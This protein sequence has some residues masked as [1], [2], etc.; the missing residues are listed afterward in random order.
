MQARE[1]SEWATRVRESGGCGS[2]PTRAGPGFWAVR[3]GKK[4][5]CKCGRAGESGPGDARETG[6]VR[7]GEGARG[8]AGPGSCRLGRRRWLGKEVSWVRVVGPTGLLVGPSGEKKGSGLG[9]ADW[10]GNWVFYWAGFF[11]GFLL[12]FPFSISNT[13]QIYFEFKRNLNSNP[14]H[15]TK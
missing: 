8:E 13:T 15:S 12:S 3:C 4:G 2:R 5:W 1:R 14:K 11:S 6:P 9:W 7:K 10:V